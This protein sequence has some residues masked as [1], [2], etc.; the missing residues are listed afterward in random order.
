MRFGRGKSVV[1][2]IAVA[3]GV[4][5]LFPASVSSAASSVEVWV[6]APAAGLWPTNCTG[7]Y[8][9]NTC[10][11]PKY[12][13]DIDSDAN[14]AKNDGDWAADLRIAGGRTLKLYV[15]PQVT[16][17]TISTFVEK[18]GEACG[19]GLKGGKLV[20]IGVYSGSSRTA[21]K[22]IGYI[23]YLHLAGVPSTFKVGAPVNRWGGTLGRV[24][25]KD[26]GLV[27]NSRCWTNP[28]VHFE[29]YNLVNYSCYNGG[30][31]TQSG[32]DPDFAAQ[33]FLGFLGG[34]RVSGARRACP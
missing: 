21:S 1:G 6:G 3:A 34:N 15:A 2:G 23:H 9:S 8:P 11:I 26:D 28:H 33:N 4:A 31:G 29:M 10:S 12:H 27:V 13:W 30:Y 19:S 25:T 20:T 32:K 5:V 17:N 7:T 16:S 14:G 22:R 18:V 24:A